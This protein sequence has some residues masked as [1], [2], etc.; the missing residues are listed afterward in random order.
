MPVPGFRSIRALKDRLIEDFG[1]EAFDFGD[2]IGEE[3][4]AFGWNLRMTPYDFSI[5]TNGGQ[6][7]S[8]IFDMQVSIV[9][10]SI[11]NG[12]VLFADMTT[13]EGVMALVSDLLPRQG[14]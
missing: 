10:A 1:A 6:L 11:D 14:N 2:E 7:C 9:D 13:T 12:D 5:S 3:Q 4:D 8:G